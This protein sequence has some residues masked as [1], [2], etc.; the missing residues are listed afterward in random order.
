MAATTFRS[1]HLAH[2]GRLPAQGSSQDLLGVQ[3][4][5]SAAFRGACVVRFLQGR[6]PSSDPRNLHTPIGPTG[7]EFQDAP[8]CSGALGADPR[9]RPSVWFPRQLNPRTA[10][11][12][13]RA[14]EVQLCMASKP[15][16]PDGGL[17]T[18]SR[19]RN[20]AHQDS[21]AT[22]LEYL[23]TEQCCS[24]AALPAASAL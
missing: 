2:R 5:H 22:G 18:A 17:A 15:P 1:S 21:H 23:I 24:P 6:S 12:L 11:L 4:V 10:V 20:Y 7:L 9:W 14:P 19:H 8:R 3:A 13:R 16:G